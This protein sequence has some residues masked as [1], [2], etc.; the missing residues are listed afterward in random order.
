MPRPRF[1]AHLLVG[2]APTSAIEYRPTPDTARTEWDDGAVRQAVVRTTVYRRVRATCMLEEHHRLYLQAWMRAHAHAWFDWLGP[3]GWRQ[4]RIAG[5]QAGVRWRQVRR[6]PGVPRWQCELDVEEV[7]LAGPENIWSGAFPKRNHD[8]QIYDH[9]ERRIRATYRP[10]PTPRYS[11]DFA[12][13]SEP[14][15]ASHPL[16]PVLFPAGS[17]AAW[18]YGFNLQWDPARTRPLRMYW[19]LSTRAD[20]AR[21]PNVV[22]PQL[23]VGALRY[24]V[25]VINRR[26]AAGNDLVVVPGA[27]GGYRDEVEPYVWR[28]GDPGGLVRGWFDRLRAQG[29]R[30]S[31]TGTVTGVDS[32]VE[33]AVVWTGPGTVVDP[34]TAHTA[35][36]GEAPVIP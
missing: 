22:G 8:S 12:V 20:L 34:W 17:P 14:V 30:D 25:H 16:S 24:L 5:G 35:L 15:A 11:V 36:G 3:S 32:A 10:R 28:L 6:S 29:E 1:P 19:S 2:G 27:T 21:P 33:W 31:G 18:T 26:S 4:S 9:R 23:R 7:D 13:R